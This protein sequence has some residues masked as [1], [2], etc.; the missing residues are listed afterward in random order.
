MS[1]SP[2]PYGMIAD[3]EPNHFMEVVFIILTLIAISIVHVTVRFWFRK[4]RPIDDH[5]RYFIKM[6]ILGMISLT[7]GWL[8]FL[9]IFQRSLIKVAT[10][11]EVRW[12]ALAGPIAEGLTAILWGTVGFLLALTCSLI[13]A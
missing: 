5:K 2:N 1:T 10:I 4:R 7:I 12:E 11:G 3:F 6:A 13:A 8:G 9:T